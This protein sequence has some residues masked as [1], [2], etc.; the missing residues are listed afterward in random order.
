MTRYQQIKAE[1]QRDPRRWVITGAAGFIGSNLLEQLLQ[2]DQVVT[3]L[4]NFATGSRGNLEQVK[5]LVSSEQWSR[6]KFIEG[7]IRDSAACHLACENAELVLHQAALGSVPMSLAEPLR[8][9][10][11]NVTGF[12][13]I[14]LSA[15]HAGVQRLVYASSCAVYGDD[16]GSQKKEEQTGNPLSPYAA[17]K[18]MNELYA[19]AFAASFS[20]DLIGLRYFN[21]FG[22]RQ[23]PA[24][25]YA[26]VIPKW[27]SSLLRHS[28]IQIYGDGE[29]SRDFVY[30]S[31]IVQANLMAALAPKSTA[32]NQVY[33]IGLGKKTSLNELFTS[34]T[35][36]VN[37]HDRSIPADQKPIYQDFRPGDIRHSLADI[38]KARQELGYEPERG[39][40]EGLELMLNWYRKIPTEHAS[41][42]PE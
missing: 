42:R 1:L 23:D 10:E 26:A 20:L 30:V 8:C 18:R 31:N 4:D 17:S 29:T 3:G 41:G 27:I 19:Q 9:H 25:T 16:P 15:K 21:V 2:L 40:E 37:H 7:D 39:M 22:P 13:N 12:L 14:L 36:L 6:F 38:S 35:R 11:T 33:N 34:L 5:A 24:G 28:A 32:K